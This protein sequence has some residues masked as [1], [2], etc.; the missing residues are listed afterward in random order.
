MIRGRVLTGTALVAVLSLLAPN[1]PTQSARAADAS[2]FPPLAGSWLGAG[3][4]AVPDGQRERIRCRA[5]YSVAPDGLKLHQELRCA[6]DSYSFDVSSTLLYKDGQVVGT[7]TER[8]RK[9]SGN[10]SGSVTGNEIRATVQG[11]GLSASLLLVMRGNRQ[12]LSILTDKPD[13]PSLAIEL[14]KD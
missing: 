14:R 7:W 1:G 8:T 5:I 10:V 12:T 3:T 13:L 6:S 11:A 2:P 4:V 9:A